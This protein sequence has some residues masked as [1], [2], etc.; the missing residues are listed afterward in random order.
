MFNDPTPIPITSLDGARVQAQAF[1]PSRLAIAYPDTAAVLVLPAMGVSA[2]FYEPLAR[3]FASRGRPTVTVDLRGQ[4]SS[5]ERAGGGASFGYREII[6]LDLPA[7]EAAVRH[8]FPRR[9]LLIV[10][11]SLGGQLATLATLRGHLQPDGLALVGA[12]SACFRHW[13]RGTRLR[14]RAVVGA[15]G[16]AA[17]ILPW[18]PGHRLGFGGAQPRELMRDWTHS[19]MT[20]R[21]HSRSHGRSLEPV[22]TPEHAP[23]LALGIEG[24]LVAPASAIAALVSRLDAS[25]LQRSELLPTSA[26]GWKRHFTWVRKP[27]DAVDAILDWNACRE[28]TVPVAHSA[29]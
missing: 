27:A 20:G 12:G 2:R 13:P 18:Y 17:R 29:A 14:C 28:V 23:V 10:A 4:G 21:Y 22:G 11:H 9:S 6:E 19:T 15:V 24:D 7:A 25:R 5:S 3:E 1:E 16:L 26:S 8:H